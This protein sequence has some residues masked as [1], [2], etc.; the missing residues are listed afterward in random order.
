MN[1]DEFPIEID[2]DLLLIVIDYY[3][4]YRLLSILLIGNNRQIIFYLTSISI[5]FR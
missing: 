3:R 1:I 4:S 5:D 2:N